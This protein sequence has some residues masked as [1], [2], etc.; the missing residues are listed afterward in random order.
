MISCSFKCVP[1]QKRPWSTFYYVIARSVVLLM[2]DIW[3]KCFSP[4]SI[5]DVIRICSFSNQT[6]SERLEF[7]WL[8]HLISTN[9]QERVCSLQWKI[10]LR[11]WKNPFRTLPMKL[12]VTVIIP[13]FL[14]SPSSLFSFVLLLLLLLEGSFFLRPYHCL[15]YI[16]T[17]VLE[18]YSNYVRLEVVQYAIHL[19]YNG[20][21]L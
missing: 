21:E 13:H 5:F 4:S 17:A 6:P 19:C 12:L 2:C 9:Q 15:H 16:Y 14:H 7:D 18:W 8:C 11:C 20:P 3:K 10:I 1:A